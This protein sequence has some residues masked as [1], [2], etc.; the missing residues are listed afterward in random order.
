M[1]CGVNVEH[2]AL[3]KKKMHIGDPNHIAVKCKMKNC[4]V[5]A[6]RLARQTTISDGI[7]SVR[8]RIHSD[9]FVSAY[10]GFE[11]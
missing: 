5:V 4:A 8:Y 1:H 6:F 10:G 3:R 2:G 11:L 9:S 7:T